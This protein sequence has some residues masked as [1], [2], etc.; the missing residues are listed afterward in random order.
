[1]TLW[2]IIRDERI[3]IRRYFSCRGHKLG[4]GHCHALTY[5]LIQIGRLSRTETCVFT[6][7]CFL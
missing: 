5:P 7:F 2:C 6:N 3:I 4:C 1:L